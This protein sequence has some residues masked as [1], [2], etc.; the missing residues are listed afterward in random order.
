M[1]TRL[2]KL[3]QPY[4]ARAETDAEKNDAEGTSKHN[5]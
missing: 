3:V 2:I 4:E 5:A 1:G